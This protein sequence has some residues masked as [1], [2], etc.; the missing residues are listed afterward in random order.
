MRVDHEREQVH[1]NDG[2]E[3][4]A[5]Q[6]RGDGCQSERGD[7]LEWF[8]GRCGPT[9]TPTEE[10]KCRTTGFRSAPG[11]RTDLNVIADTVSSPM[12]SRS[13]PTNE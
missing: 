12:V 6:M 4:K 8:A 10:Y 1:Q 13:S 5:G 7:Q 11:P 3:D 2:N 9:M